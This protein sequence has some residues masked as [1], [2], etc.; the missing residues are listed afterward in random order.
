MLLQAVLE[1]YGD[2]FKGVTSDD[3][4]KEFLGPGP[5]G[6]D[7]IK[8]VDYSIMY[9]DHPKEINPSKRIKGDYGVKVRNFRQEY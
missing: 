9:L 3:L 2:K 8:Q 4:V 5:S 7:K 6:G 1:R